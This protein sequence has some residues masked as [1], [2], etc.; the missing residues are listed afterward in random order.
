MSSSMYN[1]PYQDAFVRYIMDY[2]RGHT[3]SLR[4]AVVVSTGTEIGFAAPLAR[5]FSHVHLHLTGDIMPARQMLSRHYANH[6]E[7]G[8]FTLSTG[9]LASVQYG[10]AG[11]SV[12]MVLFDD[13]AHLAG[14][15][16]VLRSAQT[17]YLAQQ[18][19]A[20]RMWLTKGRQ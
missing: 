4:L 20:E 9:R 12:D 10:L 19:K 18:C 3:N 15:R 11:R 2:H 16:Y 8:R 14:E 7:Q 5:Y 17:V 1:A 6:W 13:C